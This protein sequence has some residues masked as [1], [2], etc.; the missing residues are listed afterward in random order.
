MLKTRHIFNYTL[1]T[2]RDIFDDFKH[3]K[4]HAARAKMGLS[5]DYAFYLDVIYRTLDTIGLNVDNIDLQ[6]IL[7][8]TAPSQPKKDANGVF[9]KDDFIAFSDP[10][11]DTF[12]TQDER[13]VES[14]IE[15]FIVSELLNN[16]MLL[17]AP[18]DIATRVVENA[19]KKK[20]KA[21]KGK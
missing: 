10:R 9:S 4:E 17:E 20:A 14:I 6:T 12:K 15:S 16:E 7:S 1:Q 2:G 13:A 11:L 3:L 21:M 8:D 18:F 5:N 19:M